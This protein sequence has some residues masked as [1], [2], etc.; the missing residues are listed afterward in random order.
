MAAGRFPYGYSALHTA[1]ISRNLKAVEVLTTQTDSAVR[2]DLDSKDSMG[3]SALHLATLQGNKHQV[4]ML[5]KAG[6]DVNSRTNEG[7]TSLHICSE[8]IDAEDILLTLATETCDVNARNKLGR[9]ALHL[10][11]KHGNT[12]NLKRLLDAGCN[13]TIKDKLGFTAVGLAFKFNHKGSAE[14][15]LHHK[16]KKNRWSSRE[17]CLDGNESEPVKRGNKEKLLSKAQSFPGVN[18]SCKKASSMLKKKNRSEVILKLLERASRGKASNF[19][20][21]HLIL[22]MLTVKRNRLDGMIISKR[23]NFLES[24]FEREVLSSFLDSSSLTSSSLVLFRCVVSLDDRLTQLCLCNFAKSVFKKRDSNTLALDFL[25]KLL[26]NLKSSILHYGSRRLTLNSIPYQCQRSSWVFIIPKLTRKENKPDDFRDFAQMLTDVFGCLSDRGISQKIT[27][28]DFETKIELDQD[29]SVLDSLEENYTLDH[30]SQ[31]CK[32]VASY[33]Y[34]LEDCLRILELM[35]NMSSTP[36]SFAG[37]LLEF[38]LENPVVF[39]RCLTYRDSIFCA[40]LNKSLT[41]DNN[42]TADKFARLFLQVC[43]GLSS[44]HRLLYKCASAVMK[45][46]IAHCDSASL[47]TCILVRMG[48][49]KGE[50]D[51]S[52]VVDL[53]GPLFALEHVFAAD[54]FPRNLAA[55]FASFLCKSSPKL[56]GLDQLRL[57]ALKS[58]VTKEVLPT[59]CQE[60]ES[61]AGRSFKRICDVMALEEDWELLFECADELFSNIFETLNCNVMRVS[62]SLLI[63]LGLL[64]SESCIE[65][66]RSFKCAVNL[67]NH[68]AKQSYFSS[69]SRAV[70][71]CFF[72]KSN[73]SLYA[74]SAEVDALLRTIRNIKAG[75]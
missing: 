12:E 19:R 26:R 32:F 49:L 73:S 72:Q 53:K 40:M 44:D 23:T 24:V 13:R 71:L 30:S 67:L 41:E 60:A 54:Y 9:T 64:K 75:L 17:S 1:V 8:R 5:L 52:S 7:M 11:A 33:V 28:Y 74:C 70:F 68:M 69:E 48:L 4:E 31:K 57:R 56:F 20:T 6:C 61:D 10:A 36:A 25:S 2:C 22:A 43:V 37:D 21:H 18:T 59:S 42:W 51:I 29:H 50:Y 14:I 63:Y 3:F 34:K 62:E 39:I 45:Q 16:P 46:G 15:L 38:C 58:A 55:I 27:D 35:I 47:G 65:I 66:V